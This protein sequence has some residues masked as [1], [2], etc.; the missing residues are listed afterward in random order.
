LRSEVLDLHSC[1]SPRQA[2]LGVN[3]ASERETSLLSPA[4]FDQLIE[5]AR[6]STFIAPGKAFLLAFEHA[7]DYNGINFQWFRSRYDRFLYIDR[8]VV[9]AKYR[10]QGYGQIL[11]ADLFER[12]DKLGHDRIACEVNLQPPNPASDRFHLAQGF[13]EVGRATL[14][15]GVKTVRYLIRWSP[16]E[17]RADL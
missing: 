4:R 8:I 7:D 10:G 14:G 3:N 16:G 1:Q 9:D 5:A 13:Q 12:A 15:G 6:V 17:S 11:Y 2:L